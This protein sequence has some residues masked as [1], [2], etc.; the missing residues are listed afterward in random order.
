MPTESSGVYAIRHIASGRLYIGSAVRVRHRWGQHLSSLRRSVHGNPP[1]QA[2]WNKYGEAAF[3]F[4]LIE[5]VP[6][7]H[8][9][10]AVEQT[11]ID[12][13]GR[14]VRLYNVCRT[15][16]SRLGVRHTAE[17]KAKLS[18]ANKGKQPSAETRAK[19]SAANRGYVA[20]DATRAKL[21]QSNRNRAYRHP[22][23]WTHAQSTRDK[24]GA[25]H[26]GH[27]RNIG[28]TKDVNSR[29]IMRA[30]AKE[31]GISEATRT[32]MAEGR[33]KRPRGKKNKRPVDQVDRRTGE[34]LCTYSNPKAAA[35]AGFSYGSLI[36]VLSGRSITHAGF[37]WTY[38]D[39]VVVDGD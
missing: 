27:T 10:T 17:T 26:K 37:Y 12:Y 14:V 32:K 29:A 31:R 16:G 2:A 22:T 6:A 9:L 36:N 5:P 19:L 7:V 11:Y 24:I 33:A 1:L 8:H 15:A 28:Q 25:A 39:Q 3:S 21:S 4:E 13:Y 35:A 38:S 30:S 20:S 34:V 23:G 18:A